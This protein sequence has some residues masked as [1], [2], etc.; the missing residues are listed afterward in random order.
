MRAAIITGCSRGLGLALCRQLLARGYQVVG[1]A[2]NPPPL[3]HTA[4]DGGRFTFISADLADSHNAGILIERAL[5]T[6]GHRP[7]E[8]LLLINNAGV[9]TP[10][11]Q[12]GNYD[13]QQVSSALAI[14]LT[15]PILLTNAFLAATAHRCNDRRILNISS[16]A[17]VNT[18][19]GWGIYGASKAA[20]DHFSRHVAEEQAGASSPARIAALYPGVVD[21]DMQSSIR[22]SDQQQFTQR[23]RFEALKRDGGLSSPEESAEK[24]LCCLNAE[25]FG[26]E[27]VLDI[28]KYS[29]D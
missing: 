16:G 17:A 23:A 28:R 12:A 29:H 13:S 6:T 24:I 19:P 1:I 10:M 15:T 3:P 25:A 21:T 26:S 2:R 14:N 8:Q 7:L 20:L 4:A 11:A 5:D 22:Q 9:V 27:T 18:Y